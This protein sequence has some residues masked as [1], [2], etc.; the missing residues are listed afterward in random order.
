MCFSI[1]PE[2]VIVGGLHD[3]DCEI[4]TVS[5]VRNFLIT[6]VL[7]KKVVDRFI[8]WAI[9]LRVIHPQRQKWGTDF[10][11]MTEEYF[12]RV[13]ENFAKHPNDPLATIPMELESLI[14]ADLDELKDWF[15][16]QICDR[17]CQTA[18][19]LKDFDSRLARIYAMLAIEASILSYTKG[20]LRIGGICIF[21]CFEFARRAKLS[22]DF[23]EAVAF[24]FA[25]N[26]ISV[27]PVRR[28]IDDRTK[29]LD[30]F[31]T[32]DQMLRC[33]TPEVFNLLKK[34]GQGSI[35]FALQLE[36][37]LYI[38]QHS[39][40][41]VM[42]IWDQVFARW[43]E[44]SEI[45]QCLTVAHVMRCKPDGIEDIPA[46][47]IRGGKCDVTELIADAVRMLTHKKSLKEEFCTYFCPKFKQFHG[48]EGKNEW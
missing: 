40:I 8:A 48:Y 22:W 16:S 39:P 41:E 5:D 10:F 46:A 4:F 47:I 45:A 38:D 35:N 7:E 27:I 29:M 9:Q 1:P 36:M 30:H 17:F 6:N 33:V 15:H 34:K 20:L 42:D 2:E 25:K 32:L 3:L 44:L 21:I 43:D 19:V 24:Y 13:T 18:S 26:V 11:V 37:F 31:E 23:A 14:R 28:I 12:K